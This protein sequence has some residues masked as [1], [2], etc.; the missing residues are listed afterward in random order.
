[1]GLEYGPHCLSKLK[2]TEIFTA[3]Y[4]LNEYHYTLY[5]YDRAGN[6]VK[7]VPPV[8]WMK[9]RT[10]PGWRRSTRTGWGIRT[11]LV[12]K[13]IRIP[14]PGAL[15][16]VTTTEKSPCMPIIPIT[17]PCAKNARRGES[18]FHY[19][20]LG[21]MAY[22]V[23]AEQ[24]QHDEGSYT[25]YDAQGR[26]VEVGVVH[27]SAL[28]AS[29]SRSSRSVSSSKTPTKM[30]AAT[31]TSPRSAWAS[32]AGLGP[33]AAATCSILAPVRRQG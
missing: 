18:A 33:S 30:V 20:F 22:S 27:E 24:E 6:L 4:E 16:T 19:D 21:R 26:I 3:E 7:T 13:R 32:S 1:M 28:N 25:R 17:N 31:T 2:T 15:L 10:Q 8:G 11:R 5:Y 12:M 9:L 14:S 29:G 23:N